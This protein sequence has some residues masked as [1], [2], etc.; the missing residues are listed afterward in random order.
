MDM[1]ANDVNN[2]PAVIGQYRV[3]C[4][5]LS[6]KVRSCELNIDQRISAVNKTETNE[7]I[8]TKMMIAGIEA[9][10]H[11]TMNTTIDK[12]GI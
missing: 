5:L 6:I 12:N 2:K 11:L 3:K 7:P 8:N 4:R 9:I 10:A 1:T